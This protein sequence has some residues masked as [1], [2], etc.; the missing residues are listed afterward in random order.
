[1]FACNLD[2]DEIFDSVAWVGLVRD[3]NRRSMLIV[4][5]LISA[6]I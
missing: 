5:P 2:A 4:D 6:D 3:C 1:M